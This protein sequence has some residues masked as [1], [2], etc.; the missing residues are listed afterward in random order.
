MFSV[1]EKNYIQDIKELTDYVRHDED[2]QEL[3]DILIK[4]ELIL[5]EL[6][7]VS[8]MEDEEMNEYGV[9]VTIHKKVYEYERQVG[10]GINHC[11]IN[12]I[13]DDKTRQSDFPQVAV[14]LKLL[15]EGII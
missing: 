7:L 1:Q 9:V 2:W 8:F 14:A 15:D 3:R 13:T 5:D 12:E 10:K 6:L 4:K 11:T